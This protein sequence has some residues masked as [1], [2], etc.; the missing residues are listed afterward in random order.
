MRGPEGPGVSTAAKA[1]RFLHAVFRT[2]VDE[3][4][5]AQNPCR[6]RGAGVERPPDRPII[7]IDQAYELADA[8][9]DRW[10][11][12]VLLA[13]FVGLRKSELLGLRRSDVNLVAHTIRVERQRQLARNGTPLIGP[14]KTDS[15]IR[16]LTLPEVL[17]PPLEDHL[18]RWSQTD[19]EGWVFTGVKGGPLSPGM[20]QKHWA[21]ARRACD[22]PPGLHFHDLRHLAGTLAAQTGYSTK[23][24]MFRLG[25][26]TQDA[27]LHYQHATAA[28]DQEIAGELDRLLRVRNGTPPQSGE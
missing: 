12:L 25:H 10:R 23:E 7:T 8:I 15:G 28:R 6:V 20:L 18:D 11:V 21:A 14:P 17:V 24:V 9:G 26:A 4:L 3:G 2:A 16:T 1:Y 5:V 19:D 22:V 27:A 13:A